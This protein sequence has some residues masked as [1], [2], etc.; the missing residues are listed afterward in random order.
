MANTVNLRVEQGTTWSY[1][2]NAQWPNGYSFNT[3]SYDLAA[4]IRKDFTD[5]HS[6]DI[7]ANGNNANVTLSL[8]ANA[9]LLMAPGNY[10]YDVMAISSANGV[11]KL[12]KGMF[13]IM[14]SATL[15]WNLATESNSLGYELSNNDYIR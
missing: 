10:I 2:F 9:T 1:S 13:S 3:A 11:T 15:V 8:T 5:N 6:T 12:Q 14:P 7:T 4:S